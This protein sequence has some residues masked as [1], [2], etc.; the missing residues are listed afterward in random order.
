MIKQIFGKNIKFEIMDKQLENILINE[1]KLYNSITTNKI[2]VKIHFTPKLIQ[3]NEQYI[4]PNIHTTTR[5]GFLADYGCCKILYLKEDILKIYIE[6]RK[7]SFIQKFKSF[8]FNTTVEAVGTILHELVL[9][10]MI[11]FFDN[12]TIIHASSFKNIKSG[13]TYIIG[14]T[15]G[16]GKTSLELLYCKKN[17]FSF[18]SDDIAVIDDNGN[19]YPNLSYPKIYA[20]NATNNNLTKLILSDDTFAGKIHWYLMK[21][22]R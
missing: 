16:V 15:G 11:Y 22:I 8:D 4:S 2:D 13:E 20:Y 12:L 5:N 9:I 7:S 1:L 6:I 21:K 3:L 10:P 17:N 18:I 14:G 19:I